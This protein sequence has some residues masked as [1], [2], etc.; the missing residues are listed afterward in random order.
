MMPAKTEV[1]HLKES[2]WRPPREPKQDKPPSDK[3]RK[4]PQANNKNR[5]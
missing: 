4:P 2:G 1:E 5:D 3:G